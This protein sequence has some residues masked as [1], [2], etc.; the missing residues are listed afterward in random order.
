MFPAVGKPGF[1]ANKAFRLK[2][3]HKIKNKPCRMGGKANQSEVHSGEGRIS[4]QLKISKYIDDHASDMIAALSSLV[5]V[6]SVRGAAES[7]M[8][9][10]KE[11]ARALSVMLNL[12]EKCVPNCFLLMHLH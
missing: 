1:R 4:M 8:P 9:Y 7:G 12:A 2:I 5:A 6:P 10:G 11:P 3:E